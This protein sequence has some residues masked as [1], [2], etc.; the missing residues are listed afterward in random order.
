MMA[1]SLGIYVH[2]PFC[3]RKCFYCDFCSSAASAQTQELYV[4]ALVKDIES[5]SYVFNDR[6]IDSIFLGGG[7]PSCLPA[8]ELG[9]IL[10]T[11]F[12]NYSVSDDAEITLE[13]NP[14]T[15][16][17]ESLLRLSE[18]GFNRLSIGL[19][20][21]HD[22]ELRALGRIHDFSDFDKT[23]ND[24]R[25]AGFKN[26]N[27]D[28]MY[29][30]PFQTEDSFGKTLEVA[31]SYSPEHISA[32]A[33]KIEP[34][35][36]F[37]ETK[38]DLILPDEDGEYNMY[39]S[40]V[41]TLKE[42]GYEHYEI[43][44]YAKPTKESRHNIKYWNCD[45]YAGFGVSAHSCLGRNRYAVVSNVNEYINSITNDTE[46]KHFSETESL[47]E[48]DF[49]EE[50]IMLRLRLKNGLSMSEYKNKFGHDID[51]KYIERMDPFIKSGH[52]IYGDECYALSD[53]GMYVSNYILSE[54]LDLE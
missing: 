29:G 14:A 53:D 20:S 41:R 25:K 32:Y 21:A 23:F 35:T 5:S 7:T 38:N 30:I 24:A 19:Q 40:A 43:S 8:R 16:D 51:K 27:L 6:V 15:A 42:M 31:A 37:Y 49:S 33:L 50:Y 11:I 52:I 18:L 3:V 34:G 1:G 12:N 26:I 54:I 22:N 9:K 39:K 4:S 13:C 17:E 47:S 46:K 28:L 48:K 10:K 45:D 2:I 44:N 36:K